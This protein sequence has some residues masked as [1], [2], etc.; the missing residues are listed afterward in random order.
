MS[1]LPTRP[2]SRIVRAA[3][4][5]LWIDGYAFAQAAR[6][7]AEQV[8]RD[9]ARWLQEARDEG[10]AE[11]RRQGD[12]QVIERLA[13]ATAQVDGYLAGLE[14]ALVDLALG[15][16]REVLDERDNAELLLCCTRKALLAFRQDQQL[17]LFVAA[18]E[19]DPV[20]DRLT[21]DSHGM[22][23]L[24]VEADAQLAAGQAR[25]SG[26]VGSVEIGLEAQLQNIRRSLLPFTGEQ[27]L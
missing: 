3:E 8:R 24:T 18:S 4:A 27:A 26:P 19:L 2:A 16:V 9:S 25:L 5:P 20:R 6:D 21:S 14:T 1:E 10:F 12:E 17:T 23:A 22:P 15:V 11:A 13:E 7:E